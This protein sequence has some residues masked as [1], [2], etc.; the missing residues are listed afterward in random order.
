VAIL[1]RS[2]RRGVPAAT[3]LGMAHDEPDPLRAPPALRGDHG[4]AWLAARQ[5]GV[6]STAQAAACGLGRGAVTRRV[7]R[8]SLHR[9]DRG[10][11]AVGHA[12]LGY[13]GRAMAAV[14]ARAPGA[15]IGLRSAWRMLGIVP[16]GIVV[17][18]VIDVVVAGRNPGRGGGTVRLHRTARWLPATCA[19]SD[20]CRSPAP[21]G[22]CSTPPSSSRTTSWSV[23][24]PKRCAG[25]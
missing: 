14:L 24:S 4:L 7:A 22:R 9:V 23:S 21:R 3:L 10:V 20:R 11:V 6:A 25:A 13:E 15:A 8:G 18:D 16:P 5:A 19:G 1:R 2:R 17:P 12:G